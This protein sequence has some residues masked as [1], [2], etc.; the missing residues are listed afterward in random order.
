MIPVVEALIESAI[1]TD[2]I[3][4]ELDSG[5]KD[6]KDL[7]KSVKEYCRKENEKREAERKATKASLKD[8]G[9]TK[10]NSRQVILPIV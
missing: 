2:A 10:D 5:V 8:N 3:R 1:H 7:T 6:G 9:K 4:N